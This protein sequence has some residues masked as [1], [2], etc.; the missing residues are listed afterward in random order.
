VGS[1]GAAHATGLADEILEIGWSEVR[2]TKAVGAAAKGFS[3]PNIP[4]GFK[5]VKDF[6]YQ[7]GQ[8]VYEY[9][10]KYYSIDVDGHNGGVWKVFENVGGRLKRI[11]TADGLL[12]IFKN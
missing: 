3:K 1:S 10:G 9:R 7:H 12:N 5:H 4:N 8:K 2:I 11:G 6:G